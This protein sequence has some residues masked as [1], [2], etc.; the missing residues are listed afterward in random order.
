MR[1]YLVVSNQSLPSDDLR[2]E[3]GKRIEAGP[4]SFFVLVPNTGAAHY[5][6]EAAATV[7]RQ[8]GTWWWA[9]NYACPATDQE[10][11]AQARQRLDKML[12][13]LA[14]L[15]APVEGDLGSQDPMEAME[16]VLADRQFDEIIMA[17]LPR[18]FSRWLEAD[19][20][21]QT[22]RRFGLPVTTTVMR[23]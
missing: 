20:P 15:G 5:D 3:L 9:T 19:L 11:T 12:A 22:E 10:A 1:K 17:T 14:A 8:P 2:E 7:L 6:A 13:D 21:R 23:L 16:K 18:R 4:C